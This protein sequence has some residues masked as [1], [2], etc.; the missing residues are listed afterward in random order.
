MAVF[1]ILSFVVC[2]TINIRLKPNRNLTDSDIKKLSIVNCISFIILIATTIWGMLMFQQ[3]IPL[4]FIKVFLFIILFVCHI[5]YMTKLT[6]IRLEMK[7]N[8][9]IYCDKC[10]MALP[11]SSEFCPECGYK[12]SKGKEV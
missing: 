7:K 6:Q 8:A 3:T 1:F 4:I 5:R 2:A 12:V 11:G 10:G 9:V